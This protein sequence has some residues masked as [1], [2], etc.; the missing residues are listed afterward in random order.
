M[1]T[2]GKKRKF[3]SFNSSI[4]IENKLKFDLEPIYGRWNTIDRS[5]DNFCID[6][7][8]QLC[9]QTVGFKFWEKVRS[10]VSDSEE[11]DLGEGHTCSQ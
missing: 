5:E 7:F 6:V 11:K 2:C 8:N 9:V 3:L 1:W 4:K 10:F